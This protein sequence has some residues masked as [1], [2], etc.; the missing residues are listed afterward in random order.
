[1]GH[2]T[3]HTIIVT[4][5]S[6]DA[7]LKAHKQASIVFKDISKIF[8]SETNAYY[9]FF[10]PPDGSKDGWPESDC[11]DKQRSAFMDWVESQAYDDGSNCLKAVEVFY[12]NP[13]FDAGIIRQS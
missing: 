3:H 6:E 10:I 2:A 12:D 9:T 13:E 8:T 11:G 1:M 4:T 7:S 5:F